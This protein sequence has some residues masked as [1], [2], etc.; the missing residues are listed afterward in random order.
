MSVA[1]CQPGVVLKAADAGA[2][3]RSLA[4]GPGRPEYRFAAQFWLNIKKAIKS[5]IR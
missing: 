3:D 5:A 4:R 1:P 2:R